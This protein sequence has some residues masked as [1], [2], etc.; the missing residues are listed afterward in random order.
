MKL[1]VGL[2]NPEV[3][4]MKTRHNV[5]FMVLDSVLQSKNL[6]L[7]EKFKSF[8]VKDGDILYAMPKTY[9]NL[10]GQAV[11]EIIKFFKLDIKDVLIVYDDISLPLGT[12]R[13]RMDGSDGGHNGIKSIIKDTGSKNFPRLKVGIGPQPI[14]IPSERFVLDNFK[15]DE[16]EKLN[17]ILKIANSFVDDWINNTDDSKLQNLYNKNHL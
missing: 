1:I 8:F 11:S 5:G 15:T 10:S 2:G 9:M 16:L 7:T 12:L 13:Y 4:Y 17:S 14:N 3:K 6:R